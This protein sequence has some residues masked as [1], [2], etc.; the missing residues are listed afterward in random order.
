MATPAPSLATVLA[1]L[2]DVLLPTRAHALINLRRY[3][4]VPARGLYLILLEVLRAH[5]AYL[6]IPRDVRINH[7]LVRERHPSTVENIEKIR[8]IFDTNIRQSD[9]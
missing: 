4:T 6:V 1:D 3:C 8:E 9:R 7:R 5:A 2:R